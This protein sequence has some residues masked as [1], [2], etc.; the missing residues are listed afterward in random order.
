[1][2]ALACGVRFPPDYTK[3]P[4]VSPRCFFAH[5]QIALVTLPDRKQRVQTLIRRGEPFTIAF[6]F[7]T[8]GFQVLLVLLCE[9]DTRMPKAISLLQISHLTRV[10]T[11]LFCNSGKRRLS[12]K[13]YNNRNENKNQVFFYRNRNFAHPKSEVNGFEKEKTGK[14]Q[15][16]TLAFYA[17]HD[18]RKRVRSGQPL[19]HL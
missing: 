1:M 8:F 2:P 14:K 6:T 5:S 7:F 15:R 19:R 4:R 12:S 13:H 17:E 3:N 11:S 18:A 9:W 16:Y 10:C